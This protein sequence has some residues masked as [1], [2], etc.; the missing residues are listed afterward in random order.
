MI[1]E[2]NSS[3][4]EPLKREICVIKHTTGAPGLRFLGLGP[5]CIP[6]NGLKKLKNACFGKYFVKITEKWK[7]FKKMLEN[8]V[9]FPG[10]HLETIS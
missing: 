8:T 2:L 10:K 1:G 7:A 6:T 3:I 4:N 5:F 9:K